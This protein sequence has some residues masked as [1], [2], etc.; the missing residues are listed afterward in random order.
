M[1]KDINSADEPIEDYG[2]GMNAYLKMLF[3]LA[4]FFFTASFAA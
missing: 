1:K 2:F 3:C 4:L